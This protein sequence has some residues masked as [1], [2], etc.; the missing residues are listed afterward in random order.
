[1]Y[2]WKNEKIK[3]LKIPIDITYTLYNNIVSKG[4]RKVK[5]ELTRVLRK[6]ANLSLTYGV[7]SNT[8][9]SISVIGGF[10]W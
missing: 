5:I 7:S 3:N 6:L 4:D 10:T 8:S 2:R 1:M 9:Y